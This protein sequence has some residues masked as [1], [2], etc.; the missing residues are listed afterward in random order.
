[1]MMSIEWVVPA[2]VGALF[3]AF[4]CLKLY[5]VRQG[6]VG[7]HDKPIGQQLCGT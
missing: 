4:G 7:E 2:L 5:G 1:M 3:T 6:I